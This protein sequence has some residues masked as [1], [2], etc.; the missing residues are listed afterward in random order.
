MKVSKCLSPAIN[1]IPTALI[2]VILTSCNS[3]YS[4]REESSIF[5][6][7][8]EYKLRVSR[9]VFFFFFLQY[10]IMNYQHSVLERYGHRNR[11]S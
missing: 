5:K 10:I 1:V 4:A 2:K 3:I 9:F 11:E 6:P 8:L 7:H